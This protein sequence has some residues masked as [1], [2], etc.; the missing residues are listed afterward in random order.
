MKMTV[1]WDVEPCTFAETDRRFRGAYS[2]HN[3]LE[4]SVNIYR[5]H[6]SAFHKTVIFRPYRKTVALRE[7]YIVLE[8]ST[9]KIGGMRTQTHV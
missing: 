4:T 9:T 6:G 8:L 7:I 5:L 3:H 2:L 1:L